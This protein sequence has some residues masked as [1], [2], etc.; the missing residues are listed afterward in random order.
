MSQIFVY[1]SS[2]KLLTGGKTFRYITQNIQVE[3]YK[4]L[5]KIT[6]IEI[7][8]WGCKVEYQY[9]QM[10]NRMLLLEIINNNCG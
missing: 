5:E 8:K 6:F 3:I 7:Q 2:K 4:K 10:W 9:T 1:I